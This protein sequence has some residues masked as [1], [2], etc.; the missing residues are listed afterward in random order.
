[1]K[2]QYTATL[3]SN[4]ASN[5]ELGV[6]R[7]GLPCFVLHVRDHFCKKLEGSGVG[8]GEFRTWKHLIAKRK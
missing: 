8:R 1:M 7:A 4:I 2:T 6:G 3:F 5:K